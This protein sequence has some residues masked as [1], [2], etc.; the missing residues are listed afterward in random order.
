MDENQL[1]ALLNRMLD[2]LGKIEDKIQ[3]GNWDAVEKLFSQINEIE[4]KIKKNPVPVDTLIKQNPSF[5]KEY[6]VIK[7]KLLE[8]AE[9]I[10]TVVGEWRNRQMEKISSSKN[11][12][13][14]LTKYF[15]PKKSSYYIDKKE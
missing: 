6:A 7:A 3:A 2:S 1:L 10:K 9:H 13:D 5:E 12:L 11:A 15:N 14:S 4:T 8:K